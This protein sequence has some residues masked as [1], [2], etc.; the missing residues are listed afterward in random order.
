VAEYTVLLAERLGLGGAELEE[1]RRGALLHDIGKIGIPDR[2]LLKPGP[3]T[4][5]ERVEMQRHPRI[6]YWIL[7]GV[8]KFRA[9]AGGSATGF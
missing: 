6:G 2:I 5:E 9:A 7:N 1:I 4:P 8:E 3:L